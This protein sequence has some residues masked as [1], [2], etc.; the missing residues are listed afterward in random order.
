VS[1]NFE[2]FLV[3]KDDNNYQSLLLQPNMFNRTLVQQ[4]ARKRFVWLIGIKIKPMLVSGLVCF[5]VFCSPLECLVCQ[6]SGLE[7]PPEEDFFP[8]CTLSNSRAFQ[9]S[10][11]PLNQLRYQLWRPPFEIHLECLPHLLFVVLAH[12]NLAVSV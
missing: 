3:G 2:R 10:Q 5:A 12:S 8:C 6:P 1:I 11:T 4:T 7:L 9:A